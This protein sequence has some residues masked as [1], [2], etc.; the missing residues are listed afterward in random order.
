MD[1]KQQWI[2]K[3]RETRQE[4]SILMFYKPVKSRGQ[5]LKQVKFIVILL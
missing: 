4:R 5:F 3:E 2:K 1:R